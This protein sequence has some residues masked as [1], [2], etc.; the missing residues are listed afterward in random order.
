MLAKTTAS[1]AVY[2]GAVAATAALAAGAFILSFIALRDLAVI[3][4]IGPDLAPVLP[5]V[6]DLAIGV[7]TLA[8]VAIGDKPARRS[9][10][11][12]RSA[13]AIAAP[14]AST[15]ASK[16]DAAANSVR[17]G[18]PA[19]RANPATAATESVPVSADDPR[20]ELAAALVV[21][22]VTRK[23]VE[24]VTC[25]LAAHD[26]G[27]PLNGIAKNVGVHHSVVSRIIDAAAAHRQRTLEAA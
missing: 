4:G 23:P 25:I 5:L 19:D 27:D 21:Q 3:A 14:G 7:A 22:K 1:G 18:A 6:I 8:L 2:R 15:A 10:I 26:A 24:V 16:R 17:A 9:R 20:R 11:A 12:T 13:G